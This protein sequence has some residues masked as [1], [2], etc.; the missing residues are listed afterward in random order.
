MPRTITLLALVAVAL[1][2]LAVAYQADLVPAS[3][4]PEAADIT[5]T[6]A[7]T[8]ADGSVH[9]VIE[10]VN[11]AAGD[12]YDGLV[13]LQL[14]VRVNGVRRR[15]PLTMTIDTGD[16][17]ATTSLGLSEGDNVIV[18]GVRVRGPRRTLAQA[19]IITTAPAAAPPPTV[20]PPP[21]QCPAALVSCQSDLD[22]CNAEL[23]D[24]E[25]N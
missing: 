16:A 10:N 4:R 21:D 11:D 25:S 24:C 12:P 6:I 13:T 20:P 9:V 3:S 22:D 14:R 1:P 5:G 15:V 19:G 7:I 8:G 17:E 23:D 18:D 2:R